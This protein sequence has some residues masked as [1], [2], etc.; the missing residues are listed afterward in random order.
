[1]IGS[2]DEDKKQLLNSSVDNKR[3]GEDIYTSNNDKGDSVRINMELGETH[4]SNDPTTGHFYVK[5]KEWNMVF[6]CCSI[7]FIIFGLYIIQVLLHML[8]A[9]KTSS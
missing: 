7:L 2:N 4:K 5:T 6:G 8:S 1:M 3:I 9:E